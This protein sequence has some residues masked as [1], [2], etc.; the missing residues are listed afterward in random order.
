VFALATDFVFAKDA[1]V[2][3]GLSLHHHG[4]SNFLHMVVLVRIARFWGG[5]FR[6]LEFGTR[7]RE[8]GRLSIIAADVPS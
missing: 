5:T 4:A 6:V 3:R 8:D 1:I 7:P 2:A